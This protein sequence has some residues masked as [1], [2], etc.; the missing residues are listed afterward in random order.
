[1]DGLVLP[2]FTLKLLRTYV[3]YTAET[4]MALTET[5]TR[6]ISNSTHIK[7]MYSR[8]TPF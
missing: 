5:Q 3:L 2:L 6:V 8:C 7:T 1:M 4:V